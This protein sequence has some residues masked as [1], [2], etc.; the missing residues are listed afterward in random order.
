V[1]DNSTTNFGFLKL[2]FVGNPDLHRVTKLARHIW[3]MG[4]RG[5]MVAGAARVRS[6]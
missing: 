2:R 5:M 6:L 4:V 3:S 1:T